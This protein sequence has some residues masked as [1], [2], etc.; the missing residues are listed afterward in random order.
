MQEI[1]NTKDKYKIIKWVGWEEIMMSVGGV[2][3]SKWEG[4]DKRENNNNNNNDN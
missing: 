2:H 4:Q 1:N 3:E